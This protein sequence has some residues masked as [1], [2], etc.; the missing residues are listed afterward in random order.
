MVKMPPNLV[1]Q[2]ADVQFQGYA[3]SGS[4]GYNRC[5]W[6]DRNGRVYQAGYNSSYSIT[7][8]LSGSHYNTM[9]PVITS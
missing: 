5:T 3:D 1:G 4:T 7:G 9:N 2:V 6:L 8:T